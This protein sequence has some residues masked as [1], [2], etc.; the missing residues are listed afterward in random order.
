MAYD[1]SLEKR[2]ARYLPKFGMIAK[3]KMFGGIGYL[4]NGNMCFGI[5]KDALVVRTSA[6]IAQD[7][8]QNEHVR[9]FDITGR[10]M[11]G[12]IM[13]K[14][15]FMSDDQSLLSMLETGFTFAVKLPAK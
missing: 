3:K 15:E 12:W 6:E 4:I 14:P 2:I 13:V 7:L 8:L 10:A 11:K 5:H 9:V 1:L